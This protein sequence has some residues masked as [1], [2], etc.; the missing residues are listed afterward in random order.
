[1][2][3]VKVP[4]AA[5]RLV[6]FIFKFLYWADVDLCD[7]NKK[8]EH[9]EASSF[10]EAMIIYR[11]ILPRLY[12]RLWARFKL[13]DAVNIQSMEINHEPKALIKWLDLTVDLDSILYH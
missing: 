8:F 6:V 13:I 5:I 10:C 9:K 3:V 1:M 11:V 12:A 4:K 2:S 7:H